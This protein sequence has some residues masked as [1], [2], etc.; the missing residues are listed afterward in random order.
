M[1]IQVGDCEAPTRGK[2]LEPESG[3]LQLKSMSYG[4]TTPEG[5]S[6]YASCGDNYM[7]GNFPPGE[8]GF[9]VY[10]NIDRNTSTLFQI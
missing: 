10:E 7:S 4:E 1:K 2:K 6:T 5:D 3:E 8:S 9:C